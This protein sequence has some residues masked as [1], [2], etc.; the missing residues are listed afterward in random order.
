MSSVQSR[1]LLTHR[2]ILQND[3]S[4][5]S[6]LGKHWLKMPACSRLLLRPN[7]LAIYLYFD[8]CPNSWVR[9]PPYSWLQRAVASWPQVLQQRGRATKHSQQKLGNF[10]NGCKWYIC[11]NISTSLC[12]QF[13]I[14]LICDLYKWMTYAHKCQWFVN[15]KFAHV[16]NG[17]ELVN[18]SKEMTRLVK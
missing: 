5:G 8:I 15:H 7:M 10:C 11:D 18:K 9:I 1:L 6:K 16:G 14:C 3:C 2:V 4:T 12:A 17:K 13:S